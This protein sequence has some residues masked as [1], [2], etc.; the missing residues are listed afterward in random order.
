[1]ANPCPHSGH[2]V[3]C[4]M[5]V[6]PIPIIR[7]TC[8]TE[9]PHS[10][11]ARSRSFLSPAGSAFTSCAGMSTS[12][13]RA[14]SPHLVIGDSGSAREPIVDRRSRGTELP[15]ALRAPEHIEHG[16]RPRNPRCPHI[17]GVAAPPVLLRPA[18]TALLG[19]VVNVADRL[20]QIGVTLDRRALESL[21][22][23]EA[24]VSS[25]RAETLGITHRKRADGTAQATLAVAGAPSPLGPPC[26]CSPSKSYLRF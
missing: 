24:N 14:T 17:L 9:S 3:A 19:I 1:M 22:K 13:H 10:R 16:L 23:D 12:T 20:E 25:P 11:S 26:H 4:A 6:A 5:V 15:E 2:V 7:S 8:R 18:D 21:L